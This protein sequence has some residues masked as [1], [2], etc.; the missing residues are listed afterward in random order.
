MNFNLI[1]G[2]R[3][4]GEF[5]SLIGLLHDTIMCN[6]VSNFTVYLRSIEEF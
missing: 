4:N 3:M 2:K 6:Y 5:T 1:M